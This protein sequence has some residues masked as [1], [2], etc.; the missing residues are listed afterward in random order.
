M[1]K[2]TL[3][4]FFLPVVIVMNSLSFSSHLVFSE[5]YL[6]PGCRERRTCESPSTEQDSTAFHGTE[7]K[8]LA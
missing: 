7:E 8:Y 5:Y 6:L 1:N 2:M 3:S 4:Y